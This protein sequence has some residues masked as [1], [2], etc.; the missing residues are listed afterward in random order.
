M[1]QKLRT[2]QVKAKEK[3]GKITTAGRRGLK[4]GQFALPDGDRPG[5]KGKYPIDT[6]GRARNALARVSQHGTSTEKRKVRAAVKRKF[7]SIGV[8]P[9]GIQGVKM[10]RYGKRY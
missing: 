10:R 7:P 5:V 4:K 1:A 6:V 9:E 3:G 8:S 2:L